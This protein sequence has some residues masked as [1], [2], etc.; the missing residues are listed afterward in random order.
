MNL[1][2]WVHSTSYEK[3]VN[4]VINR[5]RQGASRGVYAVASHMV[6]QARKSASYKQIINRADL[7]IPDG[8]SIAALMRISGA[9][10]Q[11]QVCGPDLMPYLCQE[12]EKMGVKVGFFGVWKLTL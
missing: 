1:G 5:A 6:V 7:A 10:D 4:T 2:L 12:A 11:S 8:R 9:L 3:A